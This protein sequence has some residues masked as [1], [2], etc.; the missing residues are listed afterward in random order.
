MLKNNKIKICSKKGF[1]VF[2]HT[3]CHLFWLLSGHLCPFPGS[4]LGSRYVRAPHSRH[5]YT[6][7]NPDALYDPH[8]EVYGTI[9]QPS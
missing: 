2:S 1:E 5:G 7:T 9:T 4:W 8:R 6:M 3:S